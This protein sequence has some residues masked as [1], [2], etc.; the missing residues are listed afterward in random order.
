M[1]NFVLHGH[2]PKGIKLSL[3]T[4]CPIMI[5]R[6]SENPGDSEEICRCDVVELKKEVHGGRCRSDLDCQVRKHFTDLHQKVTSKHEI[7]S[8]F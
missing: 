3:R 8:V 6:H 4:H 7:L 1:I 5:R 2:S